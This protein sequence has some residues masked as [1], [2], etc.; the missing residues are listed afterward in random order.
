[1]QPQNR[2]IGKLRAYING[3]N[4]EKKEENHD[5][6]KIK[7]DYDYEDN[8]INENPKENKTINDL[9]EETSK[10]NGSE[11]KET[12]IQASEIVENN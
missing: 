7:K 5:S 9:N 8:S 10:L 12:K 6:M 1:M 11:T 4:P 2:T 3:M